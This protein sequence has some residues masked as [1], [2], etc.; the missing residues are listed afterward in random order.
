MAA[1]KKMADEKKDGTVII[2]IPL[3]VP[4]EAAYRSRHV[5]VSTLSAMQSEALKHVT[6]ALQAGGI[7]LRSGRYVTTGA[8]AIRYILDQ[9]GE[10]A[11]LGNGNG[12]H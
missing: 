3:A 10:E 7:R 12:V 11:G 8:D 4:P 5:D 2:E 9:I 1:T 6:Q